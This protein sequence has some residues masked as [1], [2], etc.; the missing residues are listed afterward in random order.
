MAEEL[1]ENVA[2]VAETEVKAEAA[3]GGEKSAANAKGNKRYGNGG[4]RFNRE[5]SSRSP[6]S[7]RP[8]RVASV[9]DSRPLSSSVM[10][11]AN[12]VMVWASPAKYR[13]PSRRP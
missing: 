9:S 8:S 12:S 6:E 4:R 5:E 1:K 10:E 11:K 13:M 7:Q 3:Q 2:P